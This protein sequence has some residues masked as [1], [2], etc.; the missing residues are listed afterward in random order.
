MELGIDISSYL[1]EEKLGAKFYDSKKEV[2]PIDEF[3]LNGV[4]YSRIRLWHNPYSLDN[5]PY[6]GGTCDLNNFLKLAKLMISKGYRIILSSLI[7]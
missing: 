5:K 4:R 2:N 6:L 7:S 3:Y 1:E